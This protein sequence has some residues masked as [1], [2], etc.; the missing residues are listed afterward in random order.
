MVLTVIFDNSVPWASST[1]SGHFDRVKNKLL[2][3]N[4]Q[5]CQWLSYHISVWQVFLLPICNHSLH[6]TGHCAI[7]WSSLC[8]KQ[9]KYWTWLFMLMQL[10]FIACRW[11][12]TSP[13]FQVTWKPT[14]IL[15]WKSTQVAHQKEREVNGLIFVEEHIFINNNSRLRFPWVPPRNRMVS[16]A[17]G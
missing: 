17:T 14:L 2:V 13:L 5:Y 12:L 7:K 11:N 4:S 15:S 8:Y 1:P 3:L 6:S 16:I 10:I 9:S